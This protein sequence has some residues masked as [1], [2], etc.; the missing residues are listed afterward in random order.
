MVVALGLVAC[1]ADRNKYDATGSFEA[2]EVLVSAQANG[3]LLTFDITEGQSVEQGQTVGVIDTTQLYLQKMSLLTNARGVRAQRPN[4]NTQT[5]AINEQ[6]ATLEREKARVQKLIQANAANQKDLDDIES[7]ME[8]LRSQRSAQTSTL[9]K[10][11]A[12]ISAQ[13]SAI[14][15]QVAQVEDQLQKCHIV[16]PISGVILNK[17]LEAGELATMGSPLFKV[18]DINTMF[19]RAYITNN[20][21]AQAKLNDTVTIRVDGGNGEMRTYEGQIVWISDKAEFTP[22][23]IQTKDERANLVYAI[24]VSVKNDGYIKIGMYG[25]VMFNTNA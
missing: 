10:S 23:T 21:L 12:T 22:K 14:D 13:S 19:L 25:E 2:Q 5:A 24:K 11:S 3:Q 9:Q 17:Y 18:A 6:L 1:N 8:V 4:I 16:S 15:I 7:Q 20:Q